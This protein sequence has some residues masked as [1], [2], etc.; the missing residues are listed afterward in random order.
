MLKV[1]F[2]G[3]QND[4]ADET[5][6]NPIRPEIMMT[7]KR[8]REPSRASKEYVYHPRDVTECGCCPQG[9]SLTWC[10]VR[11]AVWRR[12]PTGRPRGPGMTL[13][14]PSH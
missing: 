8:S 1:T 6:I 14:I 5:E 12:A 9:A 3:R 4:L 11:L 10:L 13:P 7:Q 2:N